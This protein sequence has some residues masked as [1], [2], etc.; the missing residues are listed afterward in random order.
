MEEIITTL[1]SAGARAGTKNIF[2]VF[3]APIKRAASETRVRKGAR[4][5]N[6]LHG[7]LE[8]L[9]VNGEVI[10]C[11]HRDNLR[12]KANHSADNHTGYNG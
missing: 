2:N 12:N 10:I 1:K 6:H 8:S 4:D 7:K 9:R 3:K 5:A 11:H